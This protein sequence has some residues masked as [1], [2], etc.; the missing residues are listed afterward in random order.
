M[1]LGAWNNNLLDLKK[2]QIMNIFYAFSKTE[3][4]QVFVKIKR[5]YPFL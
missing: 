2:L 3:N 1:Q 4:F 5:T